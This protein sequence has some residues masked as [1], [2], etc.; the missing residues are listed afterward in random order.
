M[1]TMKAYHA[2]EI[3]ESVGVWPKHARKVDKILDALSDDPFSQ[4]TRGLLNVRHK[5]PDG[6][7]LGL[8]GDRGVGKTQAAACMMAG[9]K[10]SC[11]YVRFSELC[12][13]FRDAMRN[14]CEVSNLR[15]YEWPDL[16]VID[17]IDKRADTDH[18]RRTMATL[19][20]GRYGL[21]RWTLLISNDS[22]SEFMDAIGDTVASRMEESGGIRELKG[23]D[24]RGGAA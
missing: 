20:D 13:A 18:E 24:Y 22:E 14:G 7:I 21:G 3:L 11:R 12:M 10:W 23:H 17:E 9:C 19:L 5:L 16:L 6:A 2:A 1:V 15:E 4:V 8:L